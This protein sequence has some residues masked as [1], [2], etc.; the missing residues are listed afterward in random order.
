MKYKTGAENKPFLRDVESPSDN[1]SNPFHFRKNEYFGNEKPIAKKESWHKVLNNR[2]RHYTVLEAFLFVFLVIL[3]FKIY[4]L[5][6]Q[7]DTLER[8]LDSKKH[9]ES[10]LMKTKE[11]LEE[12]KVIHEIVQNVINPSSPFPKEKEG[13]VKLNS[14]FNAASLV[15]GASIETRQSSHS[16]SPGNSYFDIVS[17]ALGSDQSEFSLLDRVELPVDKAWCTDDKKPVLTV[18]L[19][20]YIKPISVSYQHSKW[21]RTV[22]NV[23][24]KLY[25]VVSCIDGD[26]NQHEPLVS[27]CEYSKSGNQEQKCLIS[28]GLPL[29]N[30]IQFR[31]HENH[32]NLNKTCVYLV[33]VYGEPSR[34]KEV[35]IQVKSQKE[36]EETAKICS[37]LA[38]FHDN[39]PVFYNGLASK[40]CSTLY[41]ND[42]CREC[43]NCCSECQI[44]DSTLL[45]NLQF[46]IIFFVLFFILF[47]MYIAGISACCFGLKR[48]FGI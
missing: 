6:S 23:A 25:D 47:P 30:K 46:F 34:S 43:P 15:L 32:G 41:S 38:W 33:R 35:K 10:H 17:F 39:I 13:K 29:V 28:T 27:N 11:I 31:F 24:P 21:N 44:N 18:N 40:N 48:F 22:P 36:E 20:D 16:V 12:K 26:C 37:R 45:N 14:E 19:A 7:I 4:S 5:Q 8:K 9:A 42:C 3:L 2:L 1:P